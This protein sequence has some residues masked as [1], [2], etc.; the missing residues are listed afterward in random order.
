MIFNTFTE[1]LKFLY[2]NIKLFSYE[3]LYYPWHNAIAIKEET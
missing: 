1:H 2:K 3:Q